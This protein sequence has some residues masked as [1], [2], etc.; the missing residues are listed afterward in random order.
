MFKSS[1]SCFGNFLNDDSKSAILLFTSLI[2]DLFANSR[3]VST[4]LSLDLLKNSDPNFSD[5]YKK[6]LGEID[7]DLQDSAGH[8][9]SPQDSPGSRSTNFP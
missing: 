9:S 1:L 3:K 6:R 7:L 5:Q 8:R 4:D 2:N